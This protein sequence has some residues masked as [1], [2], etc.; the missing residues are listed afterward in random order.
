M[1]ILPLKRH[2]FKKVPDLP[3]FPDLPI[4]GSFFGRAEK[5]LDNP[6]HEQECSAISQTQLDVG[7]NYPREESTLLQ[8]APLTGWEEQQNCQCSSVYKKV[9]IY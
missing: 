2:T 8:L 7:V 9:T 3:R 1:Y 4:E 5:Q 6:I